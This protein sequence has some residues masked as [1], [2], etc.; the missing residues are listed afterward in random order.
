M[1]DLLGSLRQTS[2]NFELIG[3]FLRHTVHN[4]GP[5]G[6]LETIISELWTY[7]DPCDIFFRSLDLLRSLQHIFFHD[8]GPTGTLATDFQDFGLYSTG[9]SRVGR[10]LGCLKI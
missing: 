5:T 2:Q 3:T 9:T 10:G 1:L 8:I 7:W 6:I 4:F